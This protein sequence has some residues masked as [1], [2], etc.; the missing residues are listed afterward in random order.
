VAGFDDL[1]VYLGGNE[2][3]GSLCDDLTLAVNNHSGSVVYVHDPGQGSDLGSLAAG[4]SSVYT[5]LS[6]SRLELR[7]AAGGGGTLVASSPPT[8]IA[9][10]GRGLT[11][12]LP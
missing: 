3:Y 9:L 10:A 12:T 1:V 4:G 8:P 7:S 5:V 2:L 11:I 6:G